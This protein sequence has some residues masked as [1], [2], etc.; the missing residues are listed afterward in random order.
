K[1]D[2]ALA[3]L[4]AA[5]QGFAARL[6]AIEASGEDDA[7]RYQFVLE[8]AIGITEDSM[9]LLAEDLGA[10]RR[11]AVLQ[12]E[13]ERQRQKERM[14]PERRKEVERA[15]QREADAQAE[16]QRKRPSLLRPGEKPGERE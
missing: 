4:L 7:W 2:G 3:D 13:S 6:S 5:E 15:G 10:R 12:E 16:R 11:E 9:E 14:A 8:D 1:P